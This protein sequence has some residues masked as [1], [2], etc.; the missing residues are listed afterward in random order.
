MSRRSSITQANRRRQWL[1]EQINWD[2]HGQNG[3]NHWKETHPRPH[4]NRQQK[5]RY[6]SVIS[7]IQQN[8]KPG[9]SHFIIFPR[10]STSSSGEV[11]RPV[12]TVGPDKA[13][14]P[15]KTDVSER[16]VRTLVNQEKAAAT[17]K[18]ETM[19]VHGGLEQNDVTSPRCLIDRHEPEPEHLDQSCH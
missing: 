3:L 17:Q 15:V 16:T 4:L 2:R 19:R 13:Q 9:N 14:S 18:D 1:R 10:H 12:N 11:T 8:S 5:S 6:H 7:T